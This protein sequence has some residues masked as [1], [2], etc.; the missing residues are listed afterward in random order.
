[1]PITIPRSHEEPLRTLAQR[2]AE[3]RALLQALRTMSGLLDREEL[4]RRVAAASNLSKE[5]VA[6]WLRMLVSMYLG[7]ADSHAT[8]ADEV[9]TLAR[10]LIGDATARD[11]VDWSAFKADLEALLACD[12]S[13]GVTAKAASVRSEYGAIY[14]RARI[15]TDLRPIFGPDPAL[16]PLAAVIVHTLRITYHDG[17]SHKDFYVALDAGDLRQ[18]RE[19]AERADRKEAS[20]RAEIARTQMRY[21]EPEV[22]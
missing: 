19:L 10:D 3:R 21:L 11:A 6:P 22:R 12:Q 15:L 17:D 14:C 13:L 7:A 4:T 9:C 2:H 20:L 18:I 1:M 8:F 16:A 5:V